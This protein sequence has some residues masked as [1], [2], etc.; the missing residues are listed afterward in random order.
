MLHQ[1]GIYLSER[2][3]QAQRSFKTLC[4]ILKSSR[5]TNVSSFSLYIFRGLCRNQHLAI[6]YLHSK[7]YVTKSRFRKTY[8]PC[9]SIFRKGWKEI[10][11][12]A[13]PQ[14]DAWM[15]LL[16][17]EQRWLRRWTVSINSSP[18]RCRLQLQSIEAAGRRMADGLHWNTHTVLY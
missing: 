13:H 4:F 2:R 12:G 8:M 14:R 5:W 3:C 7:H 16:C 6:Y 15:K 18:A 11:L 1:L 17:S 9:V 10:K